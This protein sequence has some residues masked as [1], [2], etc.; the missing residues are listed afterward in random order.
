MKPNDE[1]R[2]DVA[3]ES[4]VAKHKLPPKKKTE[5]HTRG[6]GQGTEIIVSAV[7]GGAHQTE[8][9]DWKA[10]GVIVGIKS[11]RLGPQIERIRALAKDGGRKAAHQAKLR[12]PAVLWSGRFSKRGAKFLVKHSGL[13]CA[14]LDDLGSDRTSGIREALTK[15]PH[16]WAVFSS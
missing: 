14:D 6:G 2:P 3:S 16:L 15:S 11:E 9:V 5:Q 12:L 1:S 4:A 10:V 13:L 8:T 7:T